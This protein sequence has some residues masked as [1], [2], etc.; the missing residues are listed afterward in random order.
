MGKGSEKGTHQDE[1]DLSLPRLFSLLL[2]VN[3]QTQRPIRPKETPGYPGWEG[4]LT[5]MGP[6]EIQGEDHIQAVVHEEES[7]S[8]SGILSEGTCQLEDLPALQ[9]GPPQVEGQPFPAGRHHL[10]GPGQEVGLGED[11]VIG[12]KVETGDH[13]K[14]NPGESGFPLNQAPTGIRRLPAG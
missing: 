2:A 8:A 3:R 11:G 13:T 7:L 12:D 4:S 1:V 5:Q 9:P 10:S 14:P 6:R